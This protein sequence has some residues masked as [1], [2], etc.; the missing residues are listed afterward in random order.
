MFKGFGFHIEEQ[1][2]GS[3]HLF[4][5]AYPGRPLIAVAPDPREGCP[6]GPHNELVDFI[7]G[8]LNQRGEP[9]GRTRRRR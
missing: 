2:D 4:H 1:P 5:P 9:A 6:K 7:I 3:V 8:R